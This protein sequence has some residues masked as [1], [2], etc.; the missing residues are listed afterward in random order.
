M[1]PDEFVSALGRH[2]TTAIIRTRDAALAASAMEA[3]VR[4]GVRIVEF[5]LTT[6][7]ALELI[8][9]FARRDHAPVDGI[10]RLVVG[11]GT[12]L[13]VAELEQAVLAGARFIVSPVLDLD[14]IHAANA[15][16]VAV[17]PGVHTPTE[18]LTAH[19]A[20]APLVKLFPAPAGGPAWLRA[21]LAPLPMLKVVPTQGV[22]LDNIVP[23][24]DA[25]AWAVGLVRDIFREEWLVA[26]DFASIEARVAAIRAAVLRHV[27]QTGR[28]A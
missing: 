23:W 12:V 26:R 4:G 5:T 28:S 24:L 2:R 9:E 13:T 20:G 6:P 11:A 8:T 21:V 19:R 7:G 22:D 3:A 27:A 18:M 1:T 25:G 16:G 17:L 10:T 14:I 15:A